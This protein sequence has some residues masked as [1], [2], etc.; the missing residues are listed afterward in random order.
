MAFDL[1]NFYKQTLLL[2]WTIGTG[3]FYVSAK[4]TISAGWLVISPNNST[5]REIVK[6]TATGTDASGDYVT[7]SQRGVG[8]TTEQI[9]SIGEPIRMNITAEYWDDMNDQIAAIVASGVSNANTTTMGGVEIA[10]AA[11][12]DAGTATGGTGASVVLTP[13][14]VNSSHN[15]PFVAPGT[16]GNIMKSNGTDWI[17]DTA[18]ASPFPMQNVT[19]S[20]SGGSGQEVH[21]STSNSDGSVLYVSQF[22]NT[23]AAASI[24]R[25]ARDSGTR[26]YRLT[27]SP[28]NLGLTS[29]A[30]LYAMAVA[31]N[32]LYVYCNV[33]SSYTMRR[34]DAADLANVTTITGAP[35]VA[36]GTAMF[37]DG[38]DLYISSAAATFD[39]Y[40]ISGTAISNAQ[41]ITYTSISNP[42]TAVCDGTNVW[43]GVKPSSSFTLYKYAKTGG[44]S[45]SSLT[46]ILYPT[47]EWKGSESSLFI[48]S[49]TALGV[50]W[51]YLTA[52]DATA[53]VNE[54]LHLEAMTW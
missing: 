51:G 14:N 41:T 1:Q 38:T 24:Y 23:G 21:C 50:S 54:K 29:N 18:P 40:T 45:T 31:G 27:H 49:S 13:D 7:V 43:M 15:I 20:P 35:T 44:S 53:G 33:G 2:D 25:L 39:R 42:S 10:T 37:S 19:L 22:N 5:I 26:N 48:G 36:G 12:V 32:Y 8:G 16:L 28:V 11:E 6:Y 17:S 9:H 34:Y 46:G 47:Y 4:P 30:G 52:S 3:N